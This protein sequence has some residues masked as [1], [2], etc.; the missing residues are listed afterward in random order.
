MEDKIDYNQNG[1]L[2]PFDAILNKLGELTE[3]VH[4]LRQEKETQDSDTGTRWLN[5]REVEGMLG[6]CQNTVKN[7]IRRREDPL[8][9]KRP[10]PKG[11]FFI[12]NHE[13][14][15]WMA[16]QDNI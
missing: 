3:E 12:Q 14:N 2:N 16:R 8:P 5:T 11:N 15:E 6:C 10:T 9:A 4:L 1:L 7:L 13:L